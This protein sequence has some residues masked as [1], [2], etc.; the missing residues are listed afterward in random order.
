MVVAPLSVLHNWDTE[1]KRFAPTVGVCFECYTDHHSQPLRSPHA[2]TT[3]R[4]KD[5]HCC[6]LKCFIANPQNNLRLPPALHLCPD[7]RG[8]ES[9]TPLF[10]SPC[11]HLQTLR[12]LRRKWTCSLSSSLHMKLSSGIEFIWQNMTGVTLLSMKV[13]LA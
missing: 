1:F 4:P 7:P 8:I 11:P 2:F 13:R 3:V 10:E 5:V 6:V 9:T 12:N